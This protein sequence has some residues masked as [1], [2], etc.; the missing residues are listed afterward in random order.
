LAGCQW[1]EDR[2]LERDVTAEELVGVW[3]LQPQSIRDLES[4]GIELSDDRSA[5]R[6]VFRT[7]DTCWLRTLLTD[8]TDVPGP[9]PPVTFSR[10][11]WELTAGSRQHLSL[12]LIDLPRRFTQY[13]FAA[14]GGGDLMLWQ[15]IGDPDSWDYLEF[16]KEPQAGGNF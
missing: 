6:I 13:H 14:T 7:D 15:Y 12:A 8:D 9:D 10:C 16:R 4:V 1:S 11:R 2:F 3:V 5:Y